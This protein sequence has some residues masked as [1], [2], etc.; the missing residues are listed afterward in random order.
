[1]DIASQEYVLQGAVIPAVLVLLLLVFSTFLSYKFLCKKYNKIIGL[2]PLALWYVIVLYLI[3]GLGNGFMYP[4]AAWIQSKD[5]VYATT[6]QVTSVYDA[7]APPIYYDQFTKSFAP[8][9]MVVVNGEN[10]YALRTDV[11]VGD[12]VCIE[13]STEMRIIYSIKKID[14]SDINTNQPTVITPG[15]GE[16][17][18]P[19]STEVNTGHAFQLISLYVFVGMILLEYPIGSKLVNYYIK[20]DKLVTGRIIPNRLGIIYHIVRFSPFVLLSVGIAMSD[21]ES[22]GIITMIAGFILL[23]ITIVDQ[24]TTLELKQ[25]VLIYKHLHITQKI[26]ISDIAWVKWKISKRFPYN[27]RLIIRLR[28]KAGLYI[29]LN[30]TDFWGLEN[31]YEQLLKTIEN[32]NQIDCL[33]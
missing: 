24:T 23:V 22:I 20:R 27:R 5:S 18:Q 7:P 16:L 15:T 17:K 31:M 12:W 25:D 13:W 21:N 30:Q 1:M 9:K 28:P 6:G 10:Y 2:L 33:H 26:C 14:A 32:E 4:F 11:K 3:F 19:D 29:I 8:A